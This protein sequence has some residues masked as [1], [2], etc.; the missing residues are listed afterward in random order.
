MGRVVHFEVHADD[1]ARAIT[2]YSELL[3]WTFNNWG[4]PAEYWL[5]ATGP[6]SEPGINGGM[7]RRQGP[8]PQTGQAVNAYVCTA[9]V[10][11]IDGQ[12]DKAVRLGAQIAVPKM[13]IPGVGWLVYLKDTEGNIFGMMQSDPNAA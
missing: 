8:P 12:I 5:I 10:T 13:P 11:D 4:G 7:I 9:G 1:P 3:G 6:D 2:F